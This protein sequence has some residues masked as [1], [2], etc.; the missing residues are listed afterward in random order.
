V[1]VDY[2]YTSGGGKLHE[3][4]SPAP[5]LLDAVSKSD[6]ADFANLAIGKRMDGNR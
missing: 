2:Y 4:I 6:K 1:T 3:T 5:H